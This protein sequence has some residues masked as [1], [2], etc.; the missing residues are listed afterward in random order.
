MFFYVWHTQPQIPGSA[1][2]SFPSESMVQGLKFP[3]QNPNPR[4]EEGGT[5]TPGMGQRE[6]QPVLFLREGKE[7]KLK[8]REEGGEGIFNPNNSHPKRL[9]YP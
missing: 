9:H 6:E 5:E 4:E 1:T 3:S 2:A 7:K 8:E